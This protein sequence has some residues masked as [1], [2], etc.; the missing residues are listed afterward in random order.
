LLALLWIP[1]LVREDQV[2]FVAIVGLRTGFGR[3]F[4][5]E[6]LIGFGFWLVRLL[7][8]LVGFFEVVVVL[9]LDSSECFGES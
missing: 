4:A 5:G 9:L 2:G 6:P 3:W 7:A 1:N 8:L